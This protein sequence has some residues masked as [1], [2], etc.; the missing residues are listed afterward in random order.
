MR[1]SQQTEKKPA[2]LHQKPNMHQFEISV[3]LPVCVS[4]NVRLALTMVIFLTQGSIK[5]T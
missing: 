5:S 4:S 1:E 3:T 2:M